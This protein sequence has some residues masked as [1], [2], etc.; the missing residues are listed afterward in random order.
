MQGDDRIRSEILRK[1]WRLL[2]TKCDWWQLDQYAQL[3]NE[4]HELVR[5]EFAPTKAEKLKRE[6]EMLRARIRAL[7][8]TE[9]RND[10]E[11]AA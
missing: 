7:G 10:G 9:K 5:P 6:N 1:V 2:K 11:G 3:Y 4:L 8:Q